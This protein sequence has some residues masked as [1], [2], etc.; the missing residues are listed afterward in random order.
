[1]FGGC[2][3]IHADG[4]FDGAREH[5]SIVKSFCTES[6]YITKEREVHL[7]AL[8]VKKDLDQNCVAIESSEGML[9]L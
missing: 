5:V 8:Y 7:L 1:M 9:I 4:M 6:D 2:T 3:T